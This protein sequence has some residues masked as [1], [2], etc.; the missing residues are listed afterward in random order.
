MQRPDFRKTDDMFNRVYSKDH[1]AVVCLLEDLQT[2]TRF[3]V[4]NA[5]IH[6]DPAFSD[7]KLV[8][9]A[10]LVDE[11]E[12][13]ANNFA[14]YPPPPP[15]SIT[16]GAAGSDDA[17]SGKPQR[18]PPHYSDGTKIPVV[19]CGDFNSIPGSGVYD[20]MSMGHLEGN[21]PDFL[22][23]TYGK[24]TSEGLKHRLNLKSAYATPGAGGEHHVTNFTP[25]F[26]GE[27]DYLWYSAGNLG[28]NSVLE[29][30]DTRYLEKCVGFP[31]AHF[32]SEYVWV[33][34]LSGCGTL[35][36]VCFPLLV[37]SR[38]RASSVSSRRRIL[39][40]SQ[41]TTRQLREEEVSLLGR[42]LYLCRIILQ[43]S[44]EQSGL[45]L[46]VSFSFP[47]F[48]LYSHLIPPSLRSPRPFYF[49]YFLVCLLSLLPFTVPPS[50]FP[51]F[52]P[53]YLSFR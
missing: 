32:P 34:S 9:S 52:Y 22:A 33:L 12:K 6:W 51:S 48:L 1:I 14:R 37:T 31:N 27:I 47:S 28:V 20:F 26:K 8:Q 50:F 39:A 38:S 7:V 25:G 10:L 49:R 46:L 24:F 11:I 21:H 29:Q 17:D 53:L 30:L 4:G 23:H 36:G 15:K 42:L 5:H 41:H 43:T 40:P 18:P 45:Y 35:T 13:I 19:I 44:N 16:A 2:G 3:I